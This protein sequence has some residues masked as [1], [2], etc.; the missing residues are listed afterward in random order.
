[1]GRRV[2]IVDDEP[3]IRRILSFKLRREGFV[4]FEV[5]IEI[6]LMIGA[7]FYLDP[8]QAQLYYQRALEVEGAEGYVFGRAGRSDKTVLWSK[9][10]TM[11]VTFPYTRLRLVNTL[12]EEFTIVDNQPTSPGDWD[13]VVGQITLAISEQPYYVEPK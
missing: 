6:L 9:A 13:G 12:G 4:T 3:Y 2:L 10:G 1:M 5:E 7:A 11:F 8:A